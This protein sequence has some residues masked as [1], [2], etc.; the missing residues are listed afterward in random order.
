MGAVLKNFK[1]VLV[2]EL[3]LGQLRMML[4]AEFLVD[5]IGLSK[6][7]G[8]PL[9]TMEIEEKIYEILGANLPSAAHG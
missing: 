9:S 1:Y 5:V 2:P 6:V 3:N 7:Q 4:R 8:Q